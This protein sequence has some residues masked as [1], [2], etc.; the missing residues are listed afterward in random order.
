[1]KFCIECGKEFNPQS[2]GAS[3]L[4]GPVC[5][6]AFQSRLIFPEEL[7]SICEIISKKGYPVYL[8]GGSVRDLILNRPLKDYDLATEATP[9]ILEEIFPMASLAGKSFGV[10]KYPTKEKGEFIDIAT[11]RKDGNYSDNRR[12]DSVSFTT[13]KE[14]SNRRDFTINALFLNLENKEIIDFHGGLE[15]LLKKQVRAVGNPEDRF[16]EDSLRMLRA[17]RFA[18]NLDFKIEDNTLLAIKKL[19]AS[20]HNLSKER[21]KEEINKMSQT[22]FNSFKLLKRS[23]LLGELF[24][25]AD[26]KYFETIKKMESFESFSNEEKQKWFWINL[27]VED[28][29]TFKLSNDE[30]KTLVS[31]KNI[32]N[33]LDNFNNLPTAERNECLLK[34]DFIN[35]FQYFK[36]FNHSEVVEKTLAELKANPINLNLVPSGEQLS[37]WGVS[38]GITMGKI[39]K[40]LK[41]KVHARELQKEDEVYEFVK[42]YKF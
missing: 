42:N 29:K 21:I 41:T 7:S 14:D 16:N 35:V 36:K 27:K 30:I 4:R 31:Y 24:P 28:F 6:K 5:E 23:G 19:K 12:P 9:D 34:K 10:I 1:M 40:D 25:S 2:P 39:L 3:S 33:Q 17:L 32:Y 18:S 37:Q 26:S 22:P 11:F 20:I 38:P 8:V 13:A 15:D